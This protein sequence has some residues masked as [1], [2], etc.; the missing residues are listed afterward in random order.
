[1]TV[2]T[3]KVLLQTYKF[4]IFYFF[5]FLVMWHLILFHLFLEATN[6]IFALSSYEYFL[7]KSIMY[8]RD[9]TVSQVNNSRAPALP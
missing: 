2:A 3:A 7:V 6:F 9:K 1:M 4:T 8:V 5:Y